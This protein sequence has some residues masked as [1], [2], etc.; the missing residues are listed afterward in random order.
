MTMV[1]IFTLP[2]TNRLSHVR[3]SLFL[4]PS[5]TNDYSRGKRTWKKD[6]LLGVPC[7]MQGDVF[8]VLFFSWWRDVRIQ[9]YRLVLKDE[10]ETWRRSHISW[11][12]GQVFS[13]LTFFSIF[14]PPSEVF[15]SFFLSLSCTYR[16]LHLVHVINS[17]TPPG[18]RAPRTIHSYI[19][20]FWLSHPH[21]TWLSGGCIGDWRW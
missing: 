10:K 17:H 1:M 18:K 19:R 11:W 16:L 6:E 8:L 2:L 7:D 5:S 4:S 3:I 9:W 20:Q 15:L 12:S 21:K 14:L 13:C